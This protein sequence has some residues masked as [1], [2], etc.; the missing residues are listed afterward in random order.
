MRREFLGGIAFLL[1]APTAFG[2]V[3]SVGYDCF[4]IQSGDFGRISARIDVDDG[5]KFHINKLAAASVGTWDL[6]L[7][8]IDGQRLGQ[9]EIKVHF[10][11]IDED[12]SKPLRFS[13]LSAHYYIYPLPKKA[14]YM[15]LTLNSGEHIRQSFITASMIRQWQ[16]VSRGSFGGPFETRDPAFFQALLRASSF[17]IDILSEDGTQISRTVYASKD[18]AAVIPALNR[19]DGEAIAATR[20]YRAACHHLEM[21]WDPLP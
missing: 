2:A 16:Y 9:P 19:L 3:E 15:Y 6:K 21:E 17:A 4:R 18:F 7:D 10:E 14:T 8:V 20:N 12:F 13:W 1:S 11:R 5:G